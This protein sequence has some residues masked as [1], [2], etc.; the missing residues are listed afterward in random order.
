[1]TFL[2]GKAITPRRN[3]IA[4]IV[5]LVVGVAIRPFFPAVPLC[6]SRALFDFHCPT[7]GTTTS[8]N[9]ILHGDV[10][11]AWASNPA[12]FVVLAVVCRRLLTLLSRGGDVVAK[13]NSP[14]VSHVLF[15][16]FLLLVALRAADVV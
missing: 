8:L 15:G 11:G 2:K 12:G 3:E 5:L 1:M 4:V 16:A 9:R 10:R 13:L 14:W 7:C 6:P